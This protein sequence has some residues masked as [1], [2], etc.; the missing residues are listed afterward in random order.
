MFEETKKPI[1]LVAGIIFFAVTFLISAQFAEKGE[2][3]QVSI[4]RWAF[5]GLA[6]T[7]P[8]YGVICVIQKIAGRKT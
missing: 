1:G 6:I 2:P 5:V 8:A 7:I 4:I 3:I